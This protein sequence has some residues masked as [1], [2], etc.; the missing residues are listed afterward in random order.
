MKLTNYRTLPD[1]NSEVIRMAV[2]GDIA[3]TV[4]GSR[5]TQYLA[6]FDPDV[7]LI[8]GDISYDDAIRACSYSWDNFFWNFESLDL[9]INRTIPMIL[10]IGNHDVGY[11]ALA[12]STIRKDDIDSTPF[13]FIYLPQ[14]YDPNA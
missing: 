12:T 8:G 14:H 9:V 2:G 5:L 10:S 11:D 7:L 13:Y 3:T 4:N 6:D 1:A